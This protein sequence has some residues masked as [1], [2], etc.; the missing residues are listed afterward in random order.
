[1]GFIDY[2]HFFCNVS[3]PRPVFRA[4]QPIMMTAFLLKKHLP[5]LLASLFFATS[6]T[7]QSWWRS[8]RGN[9]NVVKKDLDVADF[10]AF[11]LAFNGDVYVTQG[12][13][14]SV[15]VDMEENL[16][17]YLETD[18][19]NGKWRIKFDRNVRNRRPIK[20]FITLPTLRECYVSGS[21]SVVSE[22]TFRN[23]TDLDIGVS[24]SGDIRFAAE[25]EAVNVSVSGSGDIVLEGKAEEVDIAVSGSGDIQAHDMMTVSGRVRISGSGDV[26]IHATDDLEVRISGSGDVA[27]KGRPRLQAKSSGSGDVTA[28]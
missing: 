19:R 6:I 13:Q 11:T 21:G 12:N 10:E 1:M 24:G 4:K 2:T 27:Y 15:T 20:I 5:L 8:V 9:G 23:L 22:N 26:T 17:E 16:F 18:V 14:Q 7:A 28:M 3:E 25:A